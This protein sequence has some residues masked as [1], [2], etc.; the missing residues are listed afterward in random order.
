MYHCK[1]P[2]NCPVF[3]SLLKRIVD[4][5]INKVVIYPD[6][7]ELYMNLISDYVVK[8]VIVKSKDRE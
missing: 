4:Q 8:E 5:Y 1:K 3:C 2:D 7:I 6:N